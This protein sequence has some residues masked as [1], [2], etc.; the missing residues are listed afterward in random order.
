APAAGTPEEAQQ[1]KNSRAE[2][3]RIVASLLL[4]SP[5]SI[6]IEF[7]YGGEA[8]SPDGKADVLDLK[9]EG[10]FVAKLMLDSKS[11]QPIVLTY[12]GVSPQI[13]VQTQ[14]VQGPPPA[15]GHGGNEGDHGAGPAPQ[16]EMVD[17]TMFFD[18]Y[19]A[20][21]GVMFPHHVSRSV[22][23]KTTEEWTFK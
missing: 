14:T 22:G 10:G 11:H 7:A 17:I 4:S 20:V 5:K 18:D 9:G 13:R 6:P 2:F 15:G 3:A 21:D 23:G 16:P 19:K 12:R 8:E 1:L